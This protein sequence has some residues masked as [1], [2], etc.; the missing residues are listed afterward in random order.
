MLTRLYTLAR[1]TFLETVRQPIFGILL[2]VTAGLLMLNVALAGFTL[3]DDDKLLLD[4]GLST[5]LLSGLFLSAFSAS[6]VISREIEN[7]TALSVISKPV[8]RPVFVLGKFLGLMGALSLAFYLSF[9]VF[10]L[11]ERHGVMERSS[12]PWDAPVLVFGFGSLFV[13]IVVA[14]F[15]NYFYGSG[16]ATTTIGVITPLLTLSAIL[17]GKFG[18]T[19]E[20]IPFGSDY[21]GGQIVIAAYLVWLAVLILAAIATTA[22]TRFGQMLTLI[23]CT[24]FLALGVISDSAFGQHQGTSTAAWIAYR[25]IPNIGPF[26]VIDGITSGSEKSIVPVVYVGYMTL[27]ALLVIT[28]VLAIGVAAFQRREVG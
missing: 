15:C 9:L 5:L 12:D 14:G 3:E 25:I 16:F 18:K 17:I 24:I 23:I 6:G 2:L 4:I 22:S 19:W 27:Y 13:S 8:G 28:G 21:V 26:W 7:K 10:L 20:V 11:A 1:A